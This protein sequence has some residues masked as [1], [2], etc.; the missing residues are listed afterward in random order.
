M[1]WVPL[2]HT[3]SFRRNRLYHWSLSLTISWFCSDSLYRL[4]LTIDLQANNK[5]AYMNELLRASRRKIHISGF[6]GFGAFDWMGRWRSAISLENQWASKA[7][8]FTM[9]SMSI[10]IRHPCKMKLFVRFDEYAPM[11]RM[12]NKQSAVKLDYWCATILRSKSN[13]KVTHFTG[14][15]IIFLNIKY[16]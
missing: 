7:S 15:V 8:G 2:P 14:Q 9:L 4:T 12:S 1:P 6:A 16:C 3:A 11:S 10:N 5:F 13:I